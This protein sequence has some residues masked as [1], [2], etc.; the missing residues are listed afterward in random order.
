MAGGYLF[1]PKPL[2]T[3]AVIT[4]LRRTHAWTGF[5]GAIFFLLLGLS[6]FYLNHRAVMAIPQGGSYEVAALDVIIEPGQLTSQDDLAA[7]MKTQFDIDA[8]P[9]RRRGRGPQARPPTGRPGGQVSFNGQAANQ[10]AE[11]TASFRGPNTTI[12][13]TT[14][15]GANVVHVTRTD[16]GFIRTIIG[17]HKVIGVNTAFILLMDAMAGAI[18]FMSLSGVL[19]WTRLHGPRLAGVGILASVA[20]GAGI[21]LS[22]TWLTWAVP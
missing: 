10:P 14:Q 11:W 6:G 18:M 17:L 12:T 4:W 9:S 15:D 21:A 20:I 8:E 13:G 2:Q 3:T 7:W 19:L 22:G 1:I 16:A 5:W